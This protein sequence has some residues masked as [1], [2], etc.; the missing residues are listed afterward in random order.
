MSKYP[1]HMA[2]IVGLFLFIVTSLATANTL[3]KSNPIPGGIVL[4]PINLKSST[5]PKAY[6]DTDQVMVLANPKMV[7]HWIAVTGIP[8]DK[9][10]GNYKLDIEIDNKKSEVAFTVKNHK[11][12]SQYITLKNKRKVNPYKK[13]LERIKKE[14]KEIVS[15]LRHWQDSNKTLEEF[16]LPVKGRLSSPFGLKRFFNKQ[17]RKPHSGI[18]IAAPKGTPIVAPLSATVV[19]TG[20]YFFNGNTVFLDHGNGLITMYCHMS[21]IKVKPGQKV[22]KG[23]AIGAIGKTGRVTG[24]H[25]HWSVS[26]NDARIDPGLFFQNLD[27][28]LTH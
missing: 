20:N 5:K 28:L 13:D 23:E 17:P 22:A 19:S 1:T 8:L 14:K 10:P 24:P 21:K 27:K 4:V 2:I 16:E 3:P 7:G 25:L 11:Y 26:L 12:K 6:F 9:E 18:D 15:S